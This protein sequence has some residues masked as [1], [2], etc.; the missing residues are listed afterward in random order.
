MSNKGPIPSGSVPPG[1]QT[2]GITAEQLPAAVYHELRRLA[3]SRLRTFAPGESIQA[4][5]LVHE[6]YLRVVGSDLPA[7]VSRWNSIGHLFGAMAQAMRDELVDRARHRGRIK[8]G[9]GRRRINLD[10]DLLVSIETAGCV[11]GLDEA[12]GRLREFDSD[13]FDVVMLRYFAGLSI[14]QTALAMGIAHATVERRWRFGRAW[15][16]QRIANKVGPAHE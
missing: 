12:L 7:D 6:A 2:P 16:A 15:L 11:L 10:E 5:V 1:E 13:V 14:E 4:T 8:H 3:A 9:A